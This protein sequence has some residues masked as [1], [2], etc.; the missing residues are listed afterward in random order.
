MSSKILSPH[1]L[2]AVNQVSID[3]G[4][5]KGKTATLLGIG[6]VRT[7]TRKLQ[8]VKKVGLTQDQMTRASLLITIYHDLHTLFPG[9]TM[10]N[11]WVHISNPFFGSSPLQTMLNG[12][13]PEILKVEYYVK[14]LLRR[15]SI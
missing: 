4:L 12:G 11:S 2:C 15:G 13:I 10:A 8:N 1:A 7:L 9:Y 14:T 3:W 5:K 6:S